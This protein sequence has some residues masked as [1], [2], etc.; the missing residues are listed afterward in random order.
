MPAEPVVDGTA[1]QAW[2]REAA[3]AVDQN[4]QYLTHLD[5]VIGDADHGTNM[6][7]GFRAAVT[8]L[9]EAAPATPGAVVA[10]TGRA[11]ITNLGG[12]AGPL[13]GSGFR[14]AADVMGEDAAVSAVQLGQA[15]RAA[16]A[17]I[18]ELGAATVGDKTMVDVWDP[19]VGA[20]EAVINAGGGIV[21]A[22]RAAA[23]AAE[24]GL[25]ATVMMQA[26]KGRASYL[27]ARTI[28]HEDPG[29]A[30]SVLILCA[31]ATTIAAVA[32]KRPA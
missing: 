9:D 22:T 26:R 2:I 21:E 11:L 29:A 23:D 17:G 25:R 10:A 5:A 27:G 6:R 28:G 12:A 15:L 32:S 18:Q 19:A 13:Y 31:L 8:M 1:M 24:R 30:S 3:L 20:C 7:R 14:R 4:A 16:L